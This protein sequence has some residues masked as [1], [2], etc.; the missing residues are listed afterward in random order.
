MFNPNQEDRTEE[1]ILDAIAD[2]WES[3]LDFELEFNETDQDF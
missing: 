3:D 2:D 1:E